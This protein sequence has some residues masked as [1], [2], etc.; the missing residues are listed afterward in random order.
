MPFNEFPYTNFH[1]L[2][3]DWMIKTMK[4]VKDKAENI[5]ASVEEANDAA[6]AAKLSENNAKTSEENAKTSEENVR[7]YSDNIEEYTESLSDQI[8]T[9]TQNIA[10]NSSR[11]D[12]FTQLTNGST[13]GDAELQDI[14][15]GADGTVYATAGDAVRGQV[16]DLQD[17]IDLLIDGKYEYVIKWESGD[18]GNQGQEIDDPTYVRTDYIPC[19]I[20]RDKTY[21]LNGTNV[22]YIFYYDA[23]KHFISR[24]TTNT[25]GTFSPSSFVVYVRLETRAEHEGKVV[26]DDLINDT[27]WKQEI[28]E[29]SPKV[30]L[31]ETDDIQLKSSVIGNEGSSEYTATLADNTT[32]MIN[33]NISIKKNKVYHLHALIDENF[34]TVY[35]GHGEGQYSLYFK[36]TNTT[37][38]FMTNGNEGSQFAHGLNLNT[39]IDVM[40]IVGERNTGTIILN[41]LGGVFTR[42]VMTVSGY[43]GSVFVRPSN[44]SLSEVFIGFTCADFRQPIWMFGD[45]YFT[46]T[47][48][49]RWPYWLLE[50]GFGRCL[51]NG[52]PGENSSQ[53]LPQVTSYL[54]N[55][56]KPKYIVW[57]LGMNDPDVSAINSSWLTCV[58]SLISTC[59]QYG[60]EPILATIPNIPAYDH[61][62]KNA[63]V[64]SSGYRY[65][66]FAK[67][68]GAESAGSSW[69]AGCLASDNTHPTSYG[70]RL[71][72]L[73]ALQDVSE[74]TLGNI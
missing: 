49:S 8:A 25:D 63:W 9:N 51:L 71:L 55:N 53:T 36:I 43:N 47:S 72:C 68:V 19:D 23:S 2:N 3:Q 17:S 24:T 12:T 28:D 20:L 21:H 58:E 39:Y 22:L 26:F 4:E 31:L 69:Y 35:F 40:L 50:W 57:C 45:S 30:K 66:D 6:E 11:I 7:E 59:E 1:E 27:E 48:E 16:S 62:Y 38:T 60:I 46:H 41:T 37:I 29:M 13:T 44:C 54:A 52:F 14:R 73:Q 42:T 33:S 18:L 61:T 64:R 74:L 32:L 5:D 56:G 65:I 34:N 70:A 15:V 10:V 67:A